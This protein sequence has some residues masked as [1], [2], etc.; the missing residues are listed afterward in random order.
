M[1]FRGGIFELRDEELN[2]EVEKW[3]FENYKWPNKY[4]MHKRPKADKDD[5]DDGY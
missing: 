2:E 3:L 1:D 4:K 5:D